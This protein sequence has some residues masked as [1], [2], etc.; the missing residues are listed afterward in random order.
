MKPSNRQAGERRGGQLEAL[1]AY[2]NMGDKPED[3]RRFRLKFPTFFP[4]TPFGWTRPGFSTLTDWLYSAAEEW[5]KVYAPLDAAMSTP[6]L[7]YRDLLRCV[8]AGTDQSGGG[9]YVLYGYEK[10]ARSRGLPVTSSVVRPLLIPGESTNPLEQ[11][12]SGLP[13][14][15]PLINGVT[16]ALTWKFGC[17]FQQSVYE[18]MQCRWKARICPECGRYFIAG[19]SAQSFCSPRC[20][21]D[22]KRKR[23][24]DYWNREGSAMRNMRRKVRKTK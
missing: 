7:W 15:E 16:G 23:A 22:A 13:Q 4:V 18:L 24:L 21:G 6:L 14:G 2:A 17:E 12:T 19:K 11:Q 10:L 1:A 3:W 20:S 8:W 5:A 9:L